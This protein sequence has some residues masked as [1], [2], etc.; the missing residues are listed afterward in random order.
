MLL[1]VMEIVESNSTSETSVKMV[2]G[3]ARLIK[4]EN[5]LALSSLIST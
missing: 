1:V 5:L 3:S 2:P 4:R